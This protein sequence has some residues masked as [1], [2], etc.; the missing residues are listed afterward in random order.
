[1]NFKNNSCLIIIFTYDIVVSQT[2]FLAWTEKPR[3]KL[4]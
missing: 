2:K 4:I 1:M 3:K